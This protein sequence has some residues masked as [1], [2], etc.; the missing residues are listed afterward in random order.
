MI[1][2]ILFF[3]PLLLSMTVNVIAQVLVTRPFPFTRQLFTNEV[4]DVYQDRDG[5]VWLGTTAGLERWDGYRLRSFRST[6]ERPDLLADNHIRNLSDTPDLLWIAT[7]QG[8]MLL[9]K[10]DGRLFEPDDGRL[11]RQW[12]SGMQSDASGGMWIA[13]GRRLYHCNSTCSEVKEV[14]PFANT[15]GEH[16]VFDIYLDR[17]NNLWVMCRE[18]VLLRSRAG[19]F[20]ATTASSTI[21]PWN[22]S[23]TL[24][25]PQTSGISRPSHLLHLTSS[26]I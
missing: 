11:K 13:T 24:M 2:K 21:S 17:E 4:Y 12:V 14:N 7:D 19:G 18:G 22:T 25:A 23:A 8:L 1:R 20:E 6:S 9:N 3:L 10:S 26:T 16:D 15:K 5:Y